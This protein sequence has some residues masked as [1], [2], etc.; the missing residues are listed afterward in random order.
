MLQLI[1]VQVNKI[2][3]KPSI[4]IFRKTETIFNLLSKSKAI[5]IVDGCLFFV[6][7]MKKRIVSIIAIAN[8]AVAISLGISGCKFLLSANSAE[9]ITR[10]ECETDPSFAFIPSG[11][12]IVG[13]DRTERDFAYQISA[14][15]IATTKAEI[16]QA[17]KNLR[18]NRW[19][20]REISRQVTS[21]NNSF[22]ISRNLVTNKDYQEFVQATNYNLP[23]ISLAEYQKQGFLVH[24]YTKV[25]EF[26]WNN[27]T[28]PV[29]T[30]EHPVVLISY[31]DALAYAQWKERQTGFS[32]RLPTAAEWEKAAR[33][34]DGKYFPWGN[35]WRDDGTNAAVSGLNY[36]SAIATFPLSRSEYGVE[37]MAGN[38]FEYTSTLKW[39]ST[40]VVMKG[41]SWDDLPGFCRSAY[42]HTRPVDSKHIL[43]GFRLVRELL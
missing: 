30:E 36:T 32:Y 41:C 17:E 7:K 40:R 29:N 6:S 18:K 38:V 34:D 42:R 11:E 20:D 24:P 26:L 27:G 21:L 9:S 25:Q 2:L 19:F 13:S 39:Q 4:S 23:R 10:K 31:K 43:F 33:G 8:L 22:C 37:D 5:I 16:I 14:K 35:S 12:F 28:Y 3:R 15:S 1:P